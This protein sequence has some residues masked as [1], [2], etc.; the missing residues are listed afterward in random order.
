MHARAEC[1]H[2]KSGDDRATCNAELNRHAHAREC[3]RN[4]SQYKSENDSY[5][6]GEKV[7]VAEFLCLVAEN[8]AYVLDRS[9]FSYYGQLVAE[10]KAQ[11][12]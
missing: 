8:A 5:E 9:G 12:A 3:E 6:Y 1:S 4:A 2:E 11:L 7:R 10:L